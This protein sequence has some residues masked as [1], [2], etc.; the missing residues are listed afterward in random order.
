MQLTKQEVY[1]QVRHW[2]M[3]SINNV[4]VCA[5]ITVGASFHAADFYKMP[6]PGCLLASSILYMKIC[7]N[8]FRYSLPWKWNHI[9]HKDVEVLWSCRMLWSVV[10]RLVQTFQDSLL[11]PTLNVKMSEENAGIRELY[12]QYAL[13]P[14]SL[15]VCAPP[16]LPCCFLVPSGRHPSHPHLIVLHV[17]ASRSP[18][19][20][21]H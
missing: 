12:T 14:S 7:L 8:I 1:V 19:L 2:T 16:P 13:Y 4:I 11:V 18:F 20:S 15:P 6:A 21:E 3:Y 9:W 17:D 5:A 10:V